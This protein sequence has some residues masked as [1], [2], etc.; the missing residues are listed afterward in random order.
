MKNSEFIFWVKHNNLTVPATKNFSPGNKFYDEHLIISND[1]ELRSWVPSH[2]RLSSAILS[3][4]EILPITEGTN[5][6]YTG[7]SDGITV[8]HLSDIVGKDG[9]IVFVTDNPSFKNKNLL[10]RQNI[11]LK[12]NFDEIKKTPEN[13]FETIFIDMF[14]NTQQNFILEICKNF[15]KSNGYLM[16]LIPNSDKELTKDL[17]KEYRK[18]L[19]IIQN[20]ELGS[21]QKNQ[22]LIVAQSINF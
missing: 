2:C 21:Y 13:E 19:N 3:G 17:I 20:V 9:K 12:N 1:I 7:N 15:L 18:N 4:L 11:I 16:I 5:V 8:S 10:N 14:E 22:L 6:L